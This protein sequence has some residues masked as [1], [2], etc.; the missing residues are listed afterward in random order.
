MTLMPIRNV[1][2]P[3]ENLALRFAIDAQDVEVT[4][5]DWSHG[6]RPICEVTPYDGR[7]QVTLWPGVADVH[8]HALSDDRPFCPTGLLSKARR[9]EIDLQDGVRTG[10]T[11]D[12]N[13]AG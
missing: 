9:R 3:T 5:L 2:V 11:C 13:R 7:T 8:T 12:P 10:S 4:D 1:S 6:E